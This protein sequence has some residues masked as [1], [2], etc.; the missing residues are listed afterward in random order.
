MCLCLDLYSAV[1]LGILYL[2]FGTLPLVFRTNH[3]M[4]LW[5]S[6]LTF[7]GIITGMCLAAASNPIW[8]RRL[9]PA[10]LGGVLILIA[11]FWF[12]WTTDPSV[13]WMVP[14]VGS[15]V[16]GCGM[17][18]AFMGIFTFLVDAYPQYAA[19]AL[20]SNSFARCSISGMKNSTQYHNPC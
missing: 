7:L 17:L 20:A 6:G 9:P 3:D 1:L 15:G 19:S 4:N 13:H 2:F 16:F 8:S 5:Q 14:V 11:L 10:T 18:L 12:G